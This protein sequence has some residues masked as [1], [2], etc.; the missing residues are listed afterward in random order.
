MAP[1]PTRFYLS[2]QIE[3]V[4]SAN[5][6]VSNQRVFIGHPTLAPIIVVSK[7]GKVP[8]IRF[9]KG[10]AFFPKIVRMRGGKRVRFRVE[11]HLTFY[12]SQ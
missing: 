5:R 9:E 2:S 7:F 6:I 1:T 11:G 3:D 12:N 8:I 10:I 4:F